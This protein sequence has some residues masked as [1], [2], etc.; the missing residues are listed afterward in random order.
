[1]ILTFVSHFIIY[2]N[3]FVLFFQLHFKSLSDI[4]W[5]LCFDIYFTCCLSQWLKICCFVTEEIHWKMKHKIIFQ[6]HEPYRIQ[7]E[8]VLSSRLLDGSKEFVTYSRKVERRRKAFRRTNK[9]RLIEI[10]PAIVYLF[11]F[12][13]LWKAIFI[14]YLKNK[15]II[16]IFIHLYSMA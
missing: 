7:K 15:N 1:M 2:N 8:T 5:A 12:K 4:F 6:L 16:I 10:N 13:K 11:Y 3:N 9:S 14:R